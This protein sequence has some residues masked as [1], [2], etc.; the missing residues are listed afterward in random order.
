MSLRAVEGEAGCG[1]TTRLMGILAETLAATPLGDGQRVLALTFMHGARRRLSDRLGLVTTLVGRTDCTVIDSFAWRLVRRWRTLAAHLGL[2]VVEEGNFDAVCDVAGALLE[3][4]QVLSW[5]AS[6]FPV[7]LV[8]EGQDM[9]PERLRMLQALAEASDVLLAADEYQCLNQALRPNPLVTWIADQVQSEVLHHVHR[10]N[11]AGLRNAATAIRA[12]QVPTT[13]GAFRLVPAVSTGMAAAILASAIRW[14]PNDEIAILTPS[15]TAAFVVETVERVRAGPCGK[16]QNGPYPIVW[17]TTDDAE[18]RDLHAALNMEEVSSLATTR[19]ALHLLP[20]SGV[21]RATI[22]WVDSQASAL[23]RTEFSRAEVRAMLTRQVTL[24][25]QYGSHSRQ[26]L[27]AMTIHQAKNRE[28]D[29]VVVLWPYQVGGDAEA[30]RRL[31]YNAVTRAKRWCQV[32][33]QGQHLPNSAP[34]A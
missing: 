13:E 20:R 24:K 16:Q 6:S 19:A 26:R 31:L 23:G 25:R 22:A 18:A 15:N 9:S 3:H 34:F 2:P 27:R 30:K 7:V 12:G 8:D 17:E 28:F 5:V 14:K 10:T 32:I 4:P 29:G 1:K 21:V 11:V 33:V